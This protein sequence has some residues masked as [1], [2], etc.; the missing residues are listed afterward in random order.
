MTDPE[1]MSILIQDRERELENARVSAKFIGPSENC[2][3]GDYVIPVAASHPSWLTLPVKLP[4][5][6]KIINKRRGPWATSWEGRARRYFP[7]RRCLGK[8]IHNKLH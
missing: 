7:P 4:K 5:L 2:V 8:V 3:A 1:E 6:L